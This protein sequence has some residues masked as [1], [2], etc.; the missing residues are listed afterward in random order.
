MIKYVFLFLLSLALHQISVAQKIKNLTHREVSLQVDDSFIKTSILVQKKSKHLNNNTT[1]YWYHNNTIKS[2]QGGY[3]GNLLDGKYI[4]T[5]SSG[6]MIELG[7]LKKGVK[8]G[9]WKK[10][11]ENGQL[12]HMIT[13]RKGEKSGLFETF[14]EGVTNEKGRY[15][16]DLLHGKITT[17]GDKT[18]ATFYK[19]G[20]VVPKKERFKKGWYKFWEIPKKEAGSKT[21][22]TKKELKQKEKKEQKKDA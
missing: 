22:R 8:C 4:R 5:S 6:N 9:K 13:W 7:Y 2:N 21:P 17:Y 20:N 3:K 11:D 10:W 12:I 15:K 14:K 19:R 1:Y 18:T 16:N